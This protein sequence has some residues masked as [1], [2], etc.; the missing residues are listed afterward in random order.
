MIKKE[1]FTAAV[2]DP[3]YKAFI[4]Y[5]AALNVN[6]GDKRYSLRWAQ[7]AHLKANKAPTKIPSEYTNFTDIFLPKSAAELPEYRINNHA[8]ELVDD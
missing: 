6:S 2:L 5:V 4:L 1:E 7:I 8:I 3:E